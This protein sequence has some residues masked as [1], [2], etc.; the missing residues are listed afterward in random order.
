MDMKG[1]FLEKGWNVFVSGK[2]VLQIM[3][4]MMMTTMIIILIGKTIFPY[5][6]K[7]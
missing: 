3:M 6:L 4:M 2:S 7:K 5:H 1:V